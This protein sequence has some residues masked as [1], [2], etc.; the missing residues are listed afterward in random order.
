MDDQRPKAESDRGSMLIAAA[1]VGAALVVSWGMSSSQPRYQ[2]AASGDTVVRMDT[3]S[4]EMVACNQQRCARVEPPDRAKTFGPLTVQ[5]DSKAE[6]AL[7]K[8]DS[9][10]NSTR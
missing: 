6:P 10:A 3:D 4:G 5:F 2:L 7:P 8:S 1:I 9:P